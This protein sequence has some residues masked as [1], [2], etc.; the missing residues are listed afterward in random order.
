MNRSWH[1]RMRVKGII[2]KENNG[3]DFHSFESIPILI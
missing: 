2:E 1:E 3:N